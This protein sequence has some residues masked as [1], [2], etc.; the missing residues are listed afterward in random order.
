MNKHERDGTCAWTMNEDGIWVTTCKKAFAFE[1][2]E[3]TETGFEFCPY[4]GQPLD[5]PKPE[6]E[7]SE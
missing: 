1:L 7:V 3:V 4:C 6:P 5:N 2:G